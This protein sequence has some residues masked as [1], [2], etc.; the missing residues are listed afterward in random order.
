MRKA[1][2]LISSIIFLS[3][4]GKDR[5]EVQKAALQRA[6]DQKFEKVILSLKADCDSSVIR[7]TYKRVLQLQKSK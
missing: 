2:A 6:A 4:S 5:P 7:E 3:C 1:I